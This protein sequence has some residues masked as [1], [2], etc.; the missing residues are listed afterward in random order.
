MKLR[1]LEWF[2]TV[3]QVHA[4]SF[5]GMFEATN[6]EGEWFLVFKTRGG[7]MSTNIGRSVSWQEVKDMAQAEAQDRFTSLL[8]MWGV[9]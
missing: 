8:Y 3:E 6:V 4:I 5:D 7:R 2:G 1:P 9:R